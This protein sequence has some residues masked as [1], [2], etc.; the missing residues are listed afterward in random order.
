MVGRVAQGAG[1]GRTRVTSTASTVG[2]WTQRDGL[3]TV[4]SCQVVSAHADAGRHRCVL[5]EEGGGVALALA[6][7]VGDVVGSGGA[8][9]AA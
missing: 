7:A 5:D 6:E 4:V 9:E 8:G 1:V 3:A 2:E